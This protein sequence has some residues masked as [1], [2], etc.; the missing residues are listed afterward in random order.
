MLTNTVR[1][2]GVVKG[3]R[4]EKNG[5][6]GEIMLVVRTF[7]GMPVNESVYTKLA[8]RK[9]DHLAKEELLEIIGEYERL[10]DQDRKVCFVNY[11]VVNFNET[12]VNA[13]LL[14]SIKP[15]ERV[16]ITAHIGLYK[17]A[18]NGHVDD[19]V[20]LY[21]DSIERE[22][23]RFEEEFGLPGR[24]YAPDE[25][26]VY[27]SGRVAS[28]AEHNNALEFKISTEG[29]ENRPLPFVLY[30]PT[31]AIRKEYF[32]G[33]SVCILASAQSIDIKRTDKNGK[34]AGRD[35][36]RFVISNIAK[37]KEE[38]TA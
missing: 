10:H 3:V 21:A 24:V 9:K 5:K 26:E 8:D 28:I 11:P 1:L 29:S 13:Q 27:V 7:A 23:S 6:T 4:Y 31:E 20:F 25:N 30:R 36:H 15:G 12:T 37:K 18:D 14:K 22:V 32:V 35:L 19:R 16:F 38:K 33:D 2:K 34:R 17:K